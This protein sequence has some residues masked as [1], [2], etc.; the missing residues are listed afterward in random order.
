MLELGFHVPPEN[1]D[2]IFSQLVPP[3]ATGEK[4]GSK[5]KGKVKGKRGGCMEG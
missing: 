2:R 3:E 5:G 1:L 4:G